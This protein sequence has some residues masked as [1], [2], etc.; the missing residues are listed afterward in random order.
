MVNKRDPDITMKIIECL[1]LH[2]PKTALSIG[3]LCRL[4]DSTLYDHLSVAIVVDLVTRH[5]NFSEPDTY[6]LTDI[7]RQ[8][9]LNQAEHYL[10][11]SEKLKEAIASL[12]PTA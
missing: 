1:A 10:Q 5:R 6:E 7:G 8:T 12:S 3:L 4:S 9:V 2:G 11:L